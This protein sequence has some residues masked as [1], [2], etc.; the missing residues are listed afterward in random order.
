MD[1]RFYAQMRDNR[2]ILLCEWDNLEF[3]E[4]L[5]E[6]FEESDH[7]ARFIISYNNIVVND[8]VLK[9]KTKGKQLVRRKQDEGTNN[10]QK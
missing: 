1:Y 6:Q 10:K 3:F 7:I 4:S 9:P 5:M 8:K 2:L